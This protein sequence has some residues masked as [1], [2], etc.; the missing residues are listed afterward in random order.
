MP[1]RQPSFRRGFI[2]ALP[3]LFGYMAV[4]F[5]LAVSAVAKGFPGWAPVL[6]AGIQI[7]GTGQ[8][9]IT[10]GLTIAA[11]GAAAG[12]VA[13]SVT[14]L[15]LN[16]RYVLL[17]LALAQKLASGVTL[18]RRFLLSFSVTDEIVAMAV[19]RPF[20]PTFAYTMGL[21]ASSWLGW[22][23]GTALGV[24]CA[25]ALPESI[26]ARLGIALYAMFIAILAPVAKK[27]RPAAFCIAVAAALN[28]A[29]LA[30][31]CAVRPSGNAAL[32]A[33][34]IVAAAVCAW[35]FPHKEE[36]SAQ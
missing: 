16:L 20:R 34:G 18:R 29:L 15:A 14:C 6:L 36:A 28:V 35:K 33:S 25:S 8:G 11:D 2:D 19:T 3:I 7:S 17:S 30:L 26:L 9:A 10:N 1:D 4:G 32:L 21:L 12:C 31:P 5:T 27:S 23:G 24:A 22:T 13:A